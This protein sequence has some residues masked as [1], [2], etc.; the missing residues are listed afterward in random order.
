MRHTKQQHQTPHST[1]EGVHVSPGSSASPVED[2][3]PK[4]R[5]RQVLAGLACMLLP[6]MLY[7]PVRPSQRKNQRPYIN[8]GSV[9][10]RPRN[11]GDMSETR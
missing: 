7:F 6:V 11:T 8:P 9:V 3:Y 2:C 4:P 1:C 5:S 10:C